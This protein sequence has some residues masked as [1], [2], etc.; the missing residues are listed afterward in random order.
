MTTDKFVYRSR[1]PANAAEVFAWHMRQGA[2]QRLAPPWDRLRVL[3]DG[4][5]I[6]EGS[7]AEIEL[8][9]GPLQRHWTAEHRDIEPGRQ[10]RDLQI[11]GPFARWEHTHTIEPEGADGSWLE[12]HIDF[13]PPY[14]LIG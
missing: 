7:R 9:L 4:S 14:G 5:P 3:E 10:F 11:R 6:R 8:S 13:T 2:F 1:M 12:D